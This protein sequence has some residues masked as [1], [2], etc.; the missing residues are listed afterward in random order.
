MADVAVP[1]WFAVRLPAAASR[2]PAKYGPVPGITA[3][4]RDSAFRPGGAEGPKAVSL[5]L[6]GEEFGSRACQLA[7]TAGSLIGCRAPTA[8]R[9]RPATV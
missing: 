7:P 5:R 4:W 1:P 8:S 9:Q 6:L 3:P 2:T